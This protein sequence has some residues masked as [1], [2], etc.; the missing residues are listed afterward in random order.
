MEAALHEKLNPVFALA[1]LRS[2]DRASLQ[3]SDE[4]RSAVEKGIEILDGI[5][6]KPRNE[7]FRSD[8][9]RNY[10]ARFKT[11]Y[12]EKVR[13]GK[14]RR[15]RSPFPVETV[16]DL[17]AVVGEMT[18]RA[19][20][21]N[22][23]TTIAEFVNEILKKGLVVDKAACQLLAAQCGRSEDMNDLLEIMKVF[24]CCRECS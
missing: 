20:E 3:L 17:P 19:R 8:R 4:F 12:E 23:W 15:E 2:L 16:R 18:R 24:F 22:R 5:C 21:Q 11:A 14:L 7:Y 1:V 10:C 13:N 6:A 9:F